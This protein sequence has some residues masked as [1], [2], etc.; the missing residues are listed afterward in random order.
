LAELSWSGSGRRLSERVLGPIHGRRL[1]VLDLDPVAGRAGAV[2]TVP[3][4]RDQAFQHHGAGGLEQIG[5]DL[6]LFERRK[7]DAVRP[8]C[9]EAGKVGLAQVQGKLPQIVAIQGKDVEGVE[10]DLIVVLPAVEPVESEIPSTPRS[11]ASPSR[12]NCLVRMRRAAST[13][14]G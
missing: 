12:T 6:T 7:V 3:A 2:S 1:R 5:A 8:P 11:T 14:S 9:Q 4:F 13:I 10:L